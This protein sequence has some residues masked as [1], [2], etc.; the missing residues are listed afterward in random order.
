ML[1]AKEYSFNLP[2]SYGYQPGQ[3]VLGEE[4]FRKAEKLVNNIQ[5]PDHGLLAEMYFHYTRMTTEDGKLQEALDSITLSCFHAEGAAKQNPS[6][7]KKSPLYPHNQQPGCCPP[8]DKKIR[9]VRAVPPR[10]NLPLGFVMQTQY[11]VYCPLYSLPA[12]RFTNGR[13]CSQIAIFTLV[14]HPECS[15]LEE[16]VDIHAPLV[17]FDLNEGLRCQP[18]KRMNDS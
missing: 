3:Y 18:L 2:T 5:N 10:R 9:R 16:A 4:A 14:Q 6:A 13:D 1:N 11:M 15:E 8:R 7:K 12:S 17:H